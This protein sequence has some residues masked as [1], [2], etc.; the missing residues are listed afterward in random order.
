MK[1]RIYF[2]IA[3]DI[4][5]S[6]EVDPEHICILKTIKR[7]ENASK[8]ARG[9]VEEGGEVNLLGHCKLMAFKVV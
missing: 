9:K 5:L 1:R 8:D 2:N 3:I 4:L 6:F 7:C